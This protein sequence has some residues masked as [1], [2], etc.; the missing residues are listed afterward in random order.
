MYLQLSFRSLF[1]TYHF[2]PA[3]Y[4]QIHLCHY[5]H[6]YIITS[7]SCILFKLV[8]CPWP[9]LGHSI[10][11]SVALDPRGWPLLPWTTVSVLLA[12]WITLQT[13][14]CSA[15]WNLWVNFLKY[16]YDYIV[17]WFC[18]SGECWH[19]DVH[20]DCLQFPATINNAVMKT[21]YMFPYRSVWEFLW[22]VY[23]E[24]KFLGHGMYQL[25]S[26][27]KYNTITKPK[28]FTII[29]RVFTM[30]QTL[31]VWTRDRIICKIILVPT[32]L[33]AKKYISDLAHCFCLRNM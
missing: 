1:V 27:M 29:Y 23:P 24:V 9:F 31:C 21:L 8:F 12:R 20:L 30:H 14:D 26:V 16:S 18:S 10:I 5:Q 19:K 7:D 3:S 11:L 13:W 25:C 32:E 22:L 33:S 15:S 2:Y 17:Y 4:F 6:I 28:H